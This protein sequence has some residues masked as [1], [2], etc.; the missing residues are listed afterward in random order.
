MDEVSPNNCVVSDFHGWRRFIHGC[1]E[2]L[3]WM[4]AIHPWMLATTALD[5]GDSSM[6]VANDCLGWNRSIHG[7]C[8]RLHWMEAIHPC[9]CFCHRREAC[10]RPR[11]GC[12]SFLDRRG[13]FL[14]GFGS[15][16]TGRGSFVERC[17]SSIRSRQ[18]SPAM[19]WGVVVECRPTGSACHGRIGSCRRPGLTIRTP[20]ASA[21]W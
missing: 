14:D 6:D 9:K 3:P 16:M 11:D 4:E 21:G 20:S 12:G 2:R 17:G 10:R 13:S 1:C 8:E 15:S 19:L 18:P 5:G 7:C